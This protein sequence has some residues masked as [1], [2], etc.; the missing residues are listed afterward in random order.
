M[1][2]LAMTE[3][4][5]AGPVRPP[6]RAPRPELDSLTL[7]RCKT[8]DP[9]AFRVF[10]ATYE[11]A[12]FALLGRFL[13]RRDVEDLAQ[14]TFLRAYRGFGTFDPSHSARPSAWVLTI[15]ARLALNDRARGRPGD[16]LDDVPEPASTTTPESESTRA[17]LGRAI[18]R[19]TLAL[20]DD[21]R[22]AFVLAEYHD[23]SMEDI[24]RVLDV[25]RSTA[26]TRLFRARAKLRE[27]LAEWIDGMG[28]GAGA[29]ERRHEGP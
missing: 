13:G 16:A 10:V 8:G 19:A 1:I 2:A 24:A 28:A 11:G 22:A 4:S 12:V 21:Q 25:P 29:G 9:L 14:E 26:K 20:P 5:R 23:L 17:A 7:A 3:S 27:S 6:A 18:E 15:A